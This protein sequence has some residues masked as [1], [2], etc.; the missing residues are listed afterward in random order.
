LKI[1]PQDFIISYMNNRQIK[2]PNDHTNGKPSPRKEKMEPGE[3]ELRKIFENTTITNIKAIMSYNDITLKLVEQLE[4]HVKDLDGVI[5]QYDEK[6]DGLK[7]QIA[8]LQNKI[9]QGGS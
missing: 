2:V 5:R 6:I 1:T 8:V 3:K 9:F 4:K 7:S